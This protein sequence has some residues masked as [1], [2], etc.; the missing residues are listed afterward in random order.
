M[1]CFSL[2]DV[3]FL[4]DRFTLVGL[5]VELHHAEAELTAALAFEGTPY[6]DGSAGY[7]Q[8]YRDIVAEAINWKKQCAP[9]PSPAPAQGYLDARIIKER[10]DI[11]EVAERYTQLRKT[12]KRFIGWCP[13]HDDKSPSFVIYPESQSWHCFGCGMGGD[14]FALIMAA[15]KKDFKAAVAAV[16]SR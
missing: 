11:V 2:C 6:D 16:D 14:V 9:K 4:A 3:Y 13:V 7:W 10:T 5:R 8:E 12:G 1:I 15:E